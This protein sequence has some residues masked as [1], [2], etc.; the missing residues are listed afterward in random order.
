VLNK[1]YLLS[2][3]NDYKNDPRGCIIKN[4]Y[5]HNLMILK[6]TRGMHDKNKFL[7][8]LMILRIVPW[9]M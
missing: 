4:K 8:N 2:K 6:S 7:Y 1:I 3:F 9:V 5:M